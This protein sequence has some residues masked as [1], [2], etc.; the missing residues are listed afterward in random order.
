MSTGRPSG[1]KQR[2]IKVTKGLRAIEQGPG[3][4]MHWFTA[5]GN[6]CTGLLDT[7]ST[8]RGEPSVEGYKKKREK[9][10]G[11]TLESSNSGRRS[12]KD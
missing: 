9:K 7:P 11:E 4:Q 6:V 2:S 5:E 12:S 3:L 8:G 10:K 1:I